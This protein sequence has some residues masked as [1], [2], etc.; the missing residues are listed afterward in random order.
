MVFNLKKR[1]Q[2]SLKVNLHSLRLLYQFFIII[3][4]FTIEVTKSWSFMM[5]IQQNM[6]MIN[7][8]FLH[9]R[10]ANNKYIIITRVQCVPRIG[11]DNYAIY[12]L[13]SI[14]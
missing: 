14:E 8:A 6:Y 13:C 3:L 4:A 7:I 12:L 10:R 2:L 11:N 9:V 5:D 1:M